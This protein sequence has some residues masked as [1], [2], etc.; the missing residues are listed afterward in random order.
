MIDRRTLLASAVAGF[1]AGCS[2][3]GNSS[4]E[5]GD[6][7]ATATQGSDDPT[8][9]ATPE[10]TTT[11]TETTEDDGLQKV[12]GGG[13]DGEGDEPTGTPPEE[14]KG[15]GEKEPG[16]GADRLFDRTVD[17][18]AGDD[19][20]VRFQPTEPATL[21]YEFATIRLPVDV[22]LM[23]EEDYSELRVGELNYIE[24][25]TVLDSEEG[26]AQTRL[27]PEDGQGYVLVFDN[28]ELGEANPNTNPTLD[29][30]VSVTA[31][32]TLSDQ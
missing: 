27:E 16:R 26:R 3:S 19:H 14:K 18:P 17:I 25:G 2:G 20:Q 23:T 7:G 11:A 28:T 22:F 24:A 12:D 15:K 29:D 21:E 9:T 10:R 13:T 5:T 4:T 31:T 8:A 1:L 30:E 6:D 32:V